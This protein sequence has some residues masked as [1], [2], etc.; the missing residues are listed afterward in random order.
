MAFTAAV[1]MLLFPGFDRH[2]QL[3]QLQNL[4][5]VI[6]DTPERIGI[7]PGAGD[8]IERALYQAIRNKAVESGYNDSEFPLWEPT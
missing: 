2:R 3:E 5:H 6:P 7:A 8:C 1:D 4:S